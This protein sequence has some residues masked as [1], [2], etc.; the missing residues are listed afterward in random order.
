MDD[1]KE[2]IALIK[3]EIIPDGR[4]L[5]TGTFSSIHPLCRGCSGQGF[6][7]EVI[8]DWDLEPSSKV[9]NMFGSHKC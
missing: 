3:V 9:K 6:A 2:K 1:Y 7:R 8:R 4:G 5:Q